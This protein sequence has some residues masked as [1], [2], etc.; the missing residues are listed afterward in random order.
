[1]KRQKKTLALFVLTACLASVSVFPVSAEWKFDENAGKWQWIEYDGLYY[2]SSPET[3]NSPYARHLWI[4]GDG[5]GIAERY[6]FD[7]NGY[8]YTNTKFWNGWYL[9]VNGDGAEISNG[10]VLTTKVL[11]DNLPSGAKNSFINGLYA[12]LLGK[13]REYVDEKITEA[14]LLGDD[15]S[16]DWNY[17]VNGPIFIYGNGLKVTYKAGKA[18]TLT[19]PAG[20]FFNMN[21]DTY[22]GAEIAEALGL[23]EAEYGNPEWSEFIYWW[24]IEDENCEQIVRIIQ[25][26]DSEMADGTLKKDDVVT[27]TLSYKQIDSALIW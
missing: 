16:I 24:Q 15:L 11:T 18:C 27:V 1:M 6:Y 10:E 3:A 7:E 12:D 8:L 13:D 4:D 17:S 19:I 9:E 20:K 26:S 21:K 23:P 5:D 22:T 2:Y 14:G 25:D